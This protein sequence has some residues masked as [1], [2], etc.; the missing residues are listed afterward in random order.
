MRP[1]LKEE[2]EFA[3]WKITGTPMKFSEYSIPYLSQE[4]A[5]KTGEDPAVVSLQLIREIKQIVHDDVDQQ[6]KKCRPCGKSS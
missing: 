5:K 4:I 1:T 2:L 6:L 3:I